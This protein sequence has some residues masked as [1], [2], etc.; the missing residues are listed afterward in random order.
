M[1]LTG[2]TILQTPSLQTTNI[3]ILLSATEKDA[4]V[5]AP[6][7]R[8]M[9]KI[10]F[11]FNNLSQMNLQK[12]VDEM[13]T[14]ILSPSGDDEQSADGTVTDCDYFP[15]LAQYLVLYFHVVFFASTDSFSGHETRVN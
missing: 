6:S 4:P 15:W 10:S 11:I 14:L 5:A 3:S 13:K 1:D 12:K 9:E 8:T 2:L 7:E